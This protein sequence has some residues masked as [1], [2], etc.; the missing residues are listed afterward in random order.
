MS[1][2]GESAIISVEIA[3][4][5]EPIEGQPNRNK[6]TRIGRDMDSAIAA[7]NRRVPALAIMTRVEVVQALFDAMGSQCKL[8][9]FADDRPPPAECCVIDAAD[10]ILALLKRRLGHE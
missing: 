8:P 9:C 1:R 5:C 6:I 10:A 7:W 4:W 3:H 2:K